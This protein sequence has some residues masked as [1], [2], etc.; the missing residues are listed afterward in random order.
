MTLV[1][2]VGDGEDEDDDEDEDEDETGRLMRPVAGEGE[3][4]SSLAATDWL[5]LAFWM[6]LVHS[7]TG[8]GDARLVGED[9]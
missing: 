5:F 6:P 3:S 7:S 1:A 4:D 9:C 8:A 2:Q